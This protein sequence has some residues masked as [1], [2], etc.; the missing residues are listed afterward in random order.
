MT[1]TKKLGLA[2]LLLPFLFACKNP[3]EA[4]ATALPPTP[5]TPQAPAKQELDPRGYR[6]SHIVEGSRADTAQGT[7]QIVKTPELIHVPYYEIKPPSASRMAYMN[8]GWWT[9]K[10][11]YQPTDTTIHVNFLG[12]YL[13]FEQTQLFH[14]F[15]NGQ[16]VDTGMW[17]FDEEKQ[18]LYLACHDPYYNNSWKIMEKGFT[19]ILIGQTNENFSGIQIRWDNYKQKPF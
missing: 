6:A 5:E 14:I 11:A 2:G 13:Q 1:F 3:K 16:Q 18:I 9:A 12:K 10:M 19:M 17:S 4:T 8:T 7:T 15:Q